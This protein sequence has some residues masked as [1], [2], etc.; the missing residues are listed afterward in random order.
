MRLYLP[1]V[2]GTLISAYLAQKE[3]FTPVPARTETI[4]P[5]LPSMREQVHHWVHATQV[6]ILAGITAD[7]NHPYGPIYNG[8]LWTIPIEFLGS[9]VVFLAV[10]ASSHMAST[11]RMV[12]LS[13]LA[14]LGLRFGRWD[15]WL[16]LGGVV[17]AEWSLILL[18]AEAASDDLPTIHGTH[19]TGLNQTTSSRLSQKLWSCIKQA[20]RPVSAFKSPFKIA[21]LLISLYL[22]SYAGESSYPGYYHVPLASYIPS[23]YEP[24]FLGNE[25]F[26]LSLGAILLIFILTISPNLQSPFLSPFAQ[27]LGDISYS[28]YIV[29][30]LVLF[31]LGTGLQEL[32][33][34]QVGE[35]R[36]VDNGVGELVEG[37]V[38]TEVDGR[39]Y[40]KAFLLC[41][42]ANTVAV[43]WAADLFWRIIDGRVIGVGRR[44]EGLFVRK[45]RN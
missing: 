16:F 44:I 35:E 20:F 40:G 3:Y 5:I 13:T 25:H 23:L 37:V 30:G 31:T 11:A 33:T 21:L 28:L 18:E 45:G 29:H 17:L 7:P 6:L 10:L 9:M 22:L 12:L 15:F 4:P 43:F 26:I 32:W 8:H 2:F 14:G 27:Y 38:R 39:T 42:I 1:I 24:I 41:V 34:G 19:F 36:W